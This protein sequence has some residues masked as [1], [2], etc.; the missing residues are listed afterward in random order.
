M[1]RKLLRN[2]R[3]NIS[4]FILGLL[5]VMMI[6]FVILL[7][8]SKVFV[9]KEHASS[10]AE[11]ASLSATS[12]VYEKVEQAI[13]D[14]DNQMAS[15]KNKKIQDLQEEIDGWEEKI[16]DQEDKL[17][18]LK[19]DDKDKKGKIEEKIEDLEEKIK[20][21]EKKFSQ[22]KNNPD[23][24]IQKKIEKEEQKLKVKH[25]WS[26][27]QIY[28]NAIDNVL[29]EEM[30][31][32]KKLNDSIANALN[33]SQQKILQVVKQTTS[34][35]GGN[36]AGTQVKLFE[37]NRIKVRTSTTFKSEAFGE[38]IPKEKKDLYDEGSGPSLDFVEYLKGWSNETI[39]LE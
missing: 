8:L 6:M 2:E 15:I 4:L 22:L 24:V 32:N 17:D 29:M 36:P 7:N 38:T 3:G 19:D 39:T 18:D 5:S 16:E 14:Y 1:M 26:N 9:V 21:N 35:N 31:M 12:V 13:E 10:N 23:S 28:V 33:D 25:S 30:P 37:D 27:N 34:E 20:D 11:Q